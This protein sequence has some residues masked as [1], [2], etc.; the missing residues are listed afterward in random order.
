MINRVHEIAKNP[1]MAKEVNL[2]KAEDN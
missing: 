2:V 1:I